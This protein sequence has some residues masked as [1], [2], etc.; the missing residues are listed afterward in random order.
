[1]KSVQETH[2][3]EGRCF[4]C[5]PANEKGLRIRSFEA[6][7]ELVCEWTPEPHYLAFQNVLN[8]GICG[9]ARLPQHGP[10]R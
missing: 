9:A 3:P 8:G 7:E 4:G 10:Q 2:A 1:M 6:G 5:G